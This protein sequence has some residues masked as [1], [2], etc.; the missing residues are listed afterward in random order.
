MIRPAAFALV[1]VS[2]A[3]V[4]TR[5]QDATPIADATHLLHIEETIVVRPTPEPLTKRDRIN[6]IVAGIASPRNL[7]MTALASAQTVV[8]NQPDGR[9]DMSSIGKQFVQRELDTAISRTVEGGLGALWDEDPRWRRSGRHGFW[10]R[11]GHAVQTVMLAPRADGHLAPAW[12]RLAGNVAANAAAN[13]WLPPDQ[14]NARETALRIADTLV[15]RLINNLWAEFW[16]DIQRRLPRPP[17]P[18]ARWAAGD[19]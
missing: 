5:A 9:I 3:P 12:G 6:W 2:I 1:L 18:F 19:R 7:G 15:S 4:V 8:L 13:A 16:P 10:S 11:A 14:S 17:G